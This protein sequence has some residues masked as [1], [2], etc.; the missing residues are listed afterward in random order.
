MKLKHQPKSGEDFERIICAYYQQGYCIDRTITH[1]LR[2][3]GYKILEPEEAAADTTCQIY[4]KY[5][6][7]KNKIFEIKKYIEKIPD[8]R[9]GMVGKV[10]RESSA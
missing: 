10:C 5:W 6:N 8:K 7:P 9:G 2:S 3:R 4:L 1:Y